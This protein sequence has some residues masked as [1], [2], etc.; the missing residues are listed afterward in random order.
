MDNE[1]FSNNNSNRGDRVR[2]TDFTST[3]KK[4]KRRFLYCESFNSRKIYQRLTRMKHTSTHHREI[5]KETRF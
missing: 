5:V 1:Q 3:L 4:K 2:R